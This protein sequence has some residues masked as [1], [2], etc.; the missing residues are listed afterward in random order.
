MKEAGAGSKALAPISRSS[1]VRFP[2]LQSIVHRRC[3]TCP[4]ITLHMQVHTLPGC[5]LYSIKGFY[6]LIFLPPA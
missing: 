1:W 2:G 4:L 6:L 3:C 5:A